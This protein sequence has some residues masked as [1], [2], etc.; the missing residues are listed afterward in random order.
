MNPLTDEEYID[1][2]K[3]FNVLLTK[4]AKWSFM[5][6]HLVKPFLLKNGMVITI[7]VNPGK[8]TFTELNGDSHQWY[9]AQQKQYQEYF[10][11]SIYGD[12]NNIHAQLEDDV[13]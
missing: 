4:A 1:L 3:Q 7:Q 12:R 11:G 2:G 6:A 9:W 10:K 5:G 13:K 8:W